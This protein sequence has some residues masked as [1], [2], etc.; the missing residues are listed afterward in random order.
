MMPEIPLHVV[1][2]AFGYSGKYISRELL[3][4]GYRVRTLTNSL[5]RRNPFGERIEVYPIDFKDVNALTDSLRG[6]AALH[7]TYWVRYT[8][9]KGWV[10]FGH[11]LAVENSRILFKCARR[12][13]VKRIIHLSVTNPDKAPGWPYYVGKVKVEKILK[14]SGI[15]HSIVRPSL[16]YGGPENVLVNNIAWTIRHL[17]LFGLFGDGRYRLSPIHVED[18]AR[19]C[20]DE[21]VENGDRVVNVIG[22]ETFEYRDFVRLISRKLEKRRLIVPVPDF[23]VLLSGKLLSIIL[24][25]IVITAH[26]IRGLKEELMHVDSEPLGRIRFSLWLNKAAPTLGTTYTNDLKRRIAPGNNFPE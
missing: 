17:P 8:V 3:K 5:H 21:A 18:L 2:G 23:L 1:T 19:V 6:A 14:R 25:D 24:R 26:E 9:N 12:A 16:I 22:P 20:V 15:S 4:R 10:S 7:N 13:G 11:Q